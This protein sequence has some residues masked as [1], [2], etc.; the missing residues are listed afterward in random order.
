MAEFRDLDDDL[1]EHD[2]VT[3]DMDE[4]EAGPGILPA[5]VLAA[6]EAEKSPDA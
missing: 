2:E 4:D 6:I 1:L 5:S 3:P